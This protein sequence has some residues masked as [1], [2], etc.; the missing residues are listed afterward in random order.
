LP[1]PP[2]R[3]RLDPIFA[4][5]IVLCMNEAR[6]PTPQEIDRIAARIWNDF[7]TGLARVGWRDVVPGSQRHR[8]MVAAARAALGDPANRNIE[9]RPPAPD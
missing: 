1:A 8:Q 2:R 9:R 4:D 5:E 6:R 7:Q 3:S